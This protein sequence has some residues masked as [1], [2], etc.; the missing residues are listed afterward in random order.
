M[1]LFNGNSS[2]FLPTVSTKFSRTAPYG[3]AQITKLLEHYNRKPRCGN[4]T[5]VWV[6][7]HGGGEGD[8]FTVGGCS[9][10]KVYPYPHRGHRTTISKKSNFDTYALNGRNILFSG[11]LNKQM[12]NS[13]SVLNFWVFHLYDNKP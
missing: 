9:V 10:E 11:L 7:L 8:R 5:F 4:Y 2:E 3:M 12:P 6:Q 1:E 13:A